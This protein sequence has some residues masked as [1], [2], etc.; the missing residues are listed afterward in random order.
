MVA[1]FCMIY[2]SRKVG[3]TQES[4]RGSP[5]KPGR[6]EKE[7]EGGEAWVT[8]Y[9]GASEGRGRGSR[10]ARAGVGGMGGWGG[11]GGWGGVGEPVLERQERCRSGTFLQCVSP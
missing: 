4:L 9:D 5:P 7:I 6:T 1:D 11:L 10:P 2:S 3:K 8:K